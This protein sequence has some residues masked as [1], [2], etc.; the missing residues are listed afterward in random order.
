MLAKV[1]KGRI[2]VTGIDA[3]AGLP[4]NRVADSFDPVMN[5]VL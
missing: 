2:A 3:E 5:P 4:H 1:P